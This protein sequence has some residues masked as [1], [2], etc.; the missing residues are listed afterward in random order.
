MTPTVALLPHQVTFGDTRGQ[1]ASAFFF[2]RVPTSTR[3]RYHKDEMRLWIFII[4]V[5]VPEMNS[6]SCLTSLPLSPWSGNLTAIPARPPR[7]GGCR[8]QGLP[9]TQPRLDRLSRTEPTGRAA[10]PRL[11]A[12]DEQR[13]QARFHPRLCDARDAALTRVFWGGRGGHQ[14]PSHK[15]GA[16]AGA[17]RA[18]SGVLG[19]PPSPWRHNRSYGNRAPIAAGRRLSKPVLQ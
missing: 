10:P 15:G 6:S 19:P 12:C 8:P 7:T 13:F 18:G 16:W 1:N 17:A 4:H 2:L 9:H 3:N 14:H 5:A 11:C